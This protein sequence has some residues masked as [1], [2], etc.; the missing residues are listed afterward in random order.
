MSASDDTWAVTT[1]GGTRIAVRAAGLATRLSA[2]LIDSMIL[3]ALLV[4]EYA[5][6]A[7]VAGE[8]T[9]GQSNLVAPSG[10]VILLLSAAGFV[11]V[12]AYFTIAEVA[13]AGRTAGKAALGIRVIRVDGGPANF[14]QCLLRSL[15]Y[16]VD[17]IGIGPV[18]MFFHPQCRRLGD[19]LAGTLVVR[20]GTP[21][22]VA[23]VTAPTPVLLRSLDAGPAID[24][25]ANLGEAELAAV[26][27]FLSRSGLR[28]DQRSM[29]AARIAGRLLERLALPAGAPERMWPPELLLERL[30]LQL[31]PRFGG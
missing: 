2:A 7:A 24:G 23:T 6:V 20:E 4:F 15:A 29:L 17:I 18:L 31:A 12:V 16:A 1:A 8:T 26:R 27:T 19:L 14:V 25:L 11:I 10:S 3:G 30:Y 13:T 22:R 21:M 5:I 28:P 9:P